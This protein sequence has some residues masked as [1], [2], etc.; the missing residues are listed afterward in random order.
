[1]VI[2]IS[3][4]K[5]DYILTAVY[6]LLIIILFFIKREKNEFLIFVF[7]FFAMIFAEYIFIETGVEIFLRNS[8]LGIM[9]LWLPFLWGYGFVVIKRCSYL[10]DDIKGMSRTVLDI[11]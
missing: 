10:L 4:F 7:G 2:L 8:F 3:V 11:K 6:I 1:M 9:P 5:N